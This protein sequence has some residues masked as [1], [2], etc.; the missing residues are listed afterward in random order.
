[1]SKTVYRLRSASN[2]L[3]TCTVIFIN[4]AFA[5]ENSSSIEIN[6]RGKMRT[7]TE[8]SAKHAGKQWVVRIET[9]RKPMIRKEIDQ[10]METP[11]VYT[12]G[13]G[14]YDSRYPN[15]IVSRVSFTCGSRP[16]RDLALSAFSDLYNPSIAKIQIAG[17]DRIVLH[18]RGGDA[19]FSY[20]AELEI[21]THA[22]LAR[23]V[24]TGPP[25]A[26][27]DSGRHS[28]G[29]CA[30]KHFQI[31]DYIYPPKEPGLTGDCNAAR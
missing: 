6:A 1:M 29:I 19:G 13:I 20:S 3:L 17:E 12:F 10:V 28:I 26:G 5:A 30:T 31:T 8:V 25:P 15:H 18:L 4:F 22:I 27:C 24:A 14:D 23:R 16:F 21:G 9:K 2:R 7:T 11:S